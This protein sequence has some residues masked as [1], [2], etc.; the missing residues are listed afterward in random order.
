MAAGLVRSHAAVI[1]LK[2]VGVDALA[3]GVGANSAETLDMLYRWAD[4]VIVMHDLL[5]PCVPEAYKEKVMLCNVG[6]DRWQNPYHPELQQLVHAMIVVGP[7][8]GPAPG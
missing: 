1:R 8:N 4:K 2:A 5:L 7:A 6:E 3:A